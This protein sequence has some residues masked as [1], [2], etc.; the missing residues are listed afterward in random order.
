M[1]HENRDLDVLCEKW[2]LSTK[3]L[4]NNESAFSGRVQS[5]FQCCGKKKKIRASNLT[6]ELIKKKS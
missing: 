4:I 3:V 2:Q 5:H 1:F 6:Y